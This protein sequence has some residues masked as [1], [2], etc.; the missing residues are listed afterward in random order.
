VSSFEHF[1]EKAKVSHLEC[2]SVPNPD[3]RER[4][5]GRKRPVKPLRRSASSA[6]QIDDK[7]YQRYHQQQMDEA[8]ADMETE[9]QKPQNS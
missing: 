7:N 8:S 9:S 5:R 3:C 4:R 1:Y 2:V 6:Q